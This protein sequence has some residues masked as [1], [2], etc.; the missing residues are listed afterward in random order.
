MRKNVRAAMDALFAG[1]DYTNVSVQ[2]RQ[3]GATFTGLIADQHPTVYSYGPH[4]PLLIL[5][6]DTAYLNTTRYSATTSN[7]QSGVAHYMYYEGYENS[8][9]TIDHR[10][11]TYAVYRK[12]HTERWPTYSF[13]QYPPGHVF[14]RPAHHDTEVSR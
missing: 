9:E 5:D 10:G 4:F 3:D 11:H 12:E 8:G 13:Y 6:G 7:Q 2:T 1:K 14:A